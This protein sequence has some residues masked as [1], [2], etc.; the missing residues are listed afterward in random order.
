MPVN[1]S[2]RQKLSG[3]ILELSDV[4]NLIDP[5]D[6]Y[7]TFQPNT[8][9]YTFSATHGTFSKVDHILGHKTSLNRYKKTEITPWIL[10]DHHR[11]KL[12]FSNI[13]NNRKPTN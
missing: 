5:T 8:E 11:L 1:R 10:Y 13:R 9:E 3:E 4:I 12:D 6:I 7:R 2:F